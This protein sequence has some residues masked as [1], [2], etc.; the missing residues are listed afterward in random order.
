MATLADLQAQ[1]TGI[2][3]STS[4]IGA[5]VTAIETILSGSITPSDSDALLASLTSTA[6]NLAAQATAL[7]NIATPPATTTS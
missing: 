4:S 7:Q 1:V 6:S 2:A 5:S 3:G